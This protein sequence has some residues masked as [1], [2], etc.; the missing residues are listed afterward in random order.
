MYTLKND[1]IS[2]IN[3]IFLT[4]SRLCSS[5]FNKDEILK[6]IKDLSIHKAHAHD[7]ISIRITVKTT[8][9]LIP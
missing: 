5:D 1:G 4:E 8:N 9:S 3:Q 2:P 7:G 6:I